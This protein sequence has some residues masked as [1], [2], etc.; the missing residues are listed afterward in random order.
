MV[1]K[2]ITALSF[3]KSEAVDLF[4]ALWTNSQVMQ[5]VGFPHGLRLERHEL[6]ERH[7]KQS[8]SEFDQLLVVE[9]KATGQPIGECYLHVPMRTA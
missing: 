4:Y 2:R 1:S 3:P 7:S 9:L 8:E 6:E 5:N